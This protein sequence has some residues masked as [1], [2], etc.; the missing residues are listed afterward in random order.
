LYGS[1]LAGCTPSYINGEGAV[2]KMSMEEKMKSARGGTFG[3]GIAAYVRE[4]E[5]WRERGDLSGL[6]VGSG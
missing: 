4:I 3:K 1:A 6:E 2:D 5:E